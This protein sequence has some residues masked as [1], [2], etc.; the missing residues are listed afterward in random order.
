MKSLILVLAAVMSF[1]QVSFAKETL[2]EER[3]AEI[4]KAWQD[5]TPEQAEV[6]NARLKEVLALE[7]NKDGYKKV[8]LLGITA[9]A[10]TGVQGGMII[11]NATILRCLATSG[12][13][14]TIGAVGA[15]QLSVVLSGN[16]AVGYF[17]GDLK[18]GTRGYS[19]SAGG[20]LG[21]GGSVI[22]SDDFLIVAQGLGIGA[23]VNGSGESMF[24]GGKIDIQ[25][26]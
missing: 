8:S 10:C 5:L 13:T 11:M 4:A 1:A 6:T 20:Y 14:F 7:T 18:N 16:T 3:K 17:T 23:H 19:Y 22:V 2:A 24:G 9:F 25:I 21:I 26:D 15:F 12:Q